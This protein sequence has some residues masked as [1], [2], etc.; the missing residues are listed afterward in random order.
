[1][2]RAARRKS[3]PT[4]PDGIR[5]AVTVVHAS[6]E[7]ATW[8]LA[9]GH[10][11]G[12]PL[13]G[14]EGFLDRH[15]RGRLSDRLL[16]GAYPESEGDAVFIHAPEC[17][18]PGALVLGLGPAGEVTRTKVTRAMTAAVLKWALHEADSMTG[19]PAEPVSLGVSAALVGTNP[20]DG[21][22]LQDSLS[23]LVDGVVSAQQLIRSSS[24]LRT[25]VCVLALEIVE[26]YQERARTACA[27][28]QQLDTKT[29]ASPAV[30]L[31][32]ATE[33]QE[34]AGGVP[35]NPPADY[36]NSG[37]WRIQILDVDSDTRPPAGFRDLE[38]TSLGHR[39]TADK[40]VQRI[41]TDT[42]D[43][44]IMSAVA[45]SRPDPQLGNTLFELLV[46]HEL[47]PGLLTGG[48]IQLVVDPG[49][50]AYPW[51]A[52]A[53][54]PPGSPETAGES[55][56]ALR[57]GV[58]R[59]FSERDA[60]EARFTVRRPTGDDVLVIANPPAGD[61]IVGLP[62]AAAEGRRVAGILGKR[63]GD[64]PPYDV[65]ALI[66]DESGV[67]AEGLPPADSGLP[68]AH[69][70]N[71]LYRHE[72]RIIHIAAHGSF[73]PDDPAHSGILIGP[74]QFLTATT[75][76]SMPVVPELVFLNCCYSGR[77]GTLGGMTGQGTGGVQTASV[78]R[79]AASVARSLLLIGVRAVVAAGWA[80]DDHDAEAFAAKFYGKLLDEGVTF[81]EA[82]TAA[83]RVATHTNTWAA[84]QCYG[85][86]GFRLRS[87]AEGTDT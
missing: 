18:P 20:L 50:A 58:L 78:N 42:I 80:V 52:L 71:A 73:V 53:S 55:R 86:P 54:D 75:I 2:P 22:T 39:A 4:Q 40:L 37:W 63:R 8:P 62:G 23:A 61:S 25:L 32:V 35:G 3:P 60:R 79:L 9:V 33:V 74:G 59:Q 38:Y 36:G 72:Y 76:N 84:Y 12:M 70:V 27:V 66:W 48:N 17:A 46:P 56:F 13:R 10:V 64:H 28:L 77:V 1:M 43:S 6:L 14:A 51:E 30:T 19:I 7:H 67:E 65:H 24:R 57:Y 68:F 83:R 26:L 15:L 81:G 82:V 11:Q 44:L 45:S 16:V 21:I 41:Q 5:L 87:L 31:E 47:K 85:D 49:T 69:I 29:L 34:G